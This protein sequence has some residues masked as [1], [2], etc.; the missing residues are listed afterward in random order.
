[1]NDVSQNSGVVYWITGLSGVGKTTVAALLYE[2]LTE[3]GIN[4][5]H[6]DGDRLREVLSAETAHSENERYTLAFTYVRL[7]KML[8]EQGLSVI[9]STMSL[10]NDVRSWG[11]VHTPN[12][13]EVHLT[14]PMAILHARDPKGLYARAVAGKMDNV[15]AM[16]M[17]YEAPTQ[18]DLEILNDGSFPPED[19][20]EKI[21]NL[22]VQR[23]LFVGD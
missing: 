13:V 18:S 19:A 20:V 9:C 15:A 7:C 14:A 5:V 2:R 8:A 10:F 11:R 12:W 21:I 6:L 16:D 3:R 1:M 22:A 23:G 4:A 17:P